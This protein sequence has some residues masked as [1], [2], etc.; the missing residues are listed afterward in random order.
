MGGSFNFHNKLSYCEGINS[1]NGVLHTILGNQYDLGS[2]R[3]D[4]IANTTKG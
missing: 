4:K 1:K 3:N 2:E